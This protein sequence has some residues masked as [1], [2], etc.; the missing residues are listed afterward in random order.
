VIDGIAQ[1]SLE[2]G[3]WSIEFED[4]GLQSLPPGWLSEWRGNGIISRTADTKMARFLRG[5]KLPIVELLG[6]PDIGGAEV[7]VDSNSGGRI[8]VEHFLN[9]GL[10][11]FGYFSYGSTWWTRLLERGFLQALEGHGYPCHSYMPP[12]ERHGKDPSIWPVWHEIQKPRLRKWLQALPRPIGIHTA[13]DLHAMRL[14]NICREMDIAVPE[15]I[16]ILG[17][18]DDT[19]ICQSVRPTLSSIDLNT[20]RIGYEAARLLDLKMS[21]KPTPKERIDVP[22]SHVT[23]RQST[24]LMVIEDPDVVEAMRFIRSRACS[25]VDVLRVAEEVGL[26]RKALERR[27]QRYLGRAPKSEIMRV[28]IERAKALLTRTDQTLE[29]IVHRCGFASLKYFSRA[30]RREVGMPPNAYRRMQRMARDSEE[31]P[32]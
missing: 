14:L 5:T 7:L 29:S 16:A 1:Y 12:E 20:Q 17:I 8:A 24:D 26:S 32:V 9:C 28:Q 10:R 15:E 30:F 6:H 27:F 21:G 19:M 4:R 23:V 3:P 11:Q 25:G 22:A 18:G 31:T 2:H 13:G